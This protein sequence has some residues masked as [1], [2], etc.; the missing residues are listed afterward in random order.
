MQFFTPSSLV[1]LWALPALW[2]L[3]WL[4][5]RMWTARVARIGMPQ[6]LT[7]KLMPLYRPH[8]WQ[9]RAILLTLGILFAVLALA[10]PQW[11]SEK[12]KIERQGID[13][14]FLLDTSLSMLA[15]DAKPN[16]LEKSKLE[17][18][19]F[20]R[21][22]KGDRVG[23]VAFAGSGFLQTPL[24]LDYPAFLLFLDGVKTG[25]IPDPGTSLDQAIHVAMESM[26]EKELKHKALV[27]FSDG[28]DHEGGLER[29]IDEAKKA[30][31]RVYTVGVGSAQ[32]EPIQLSD[33]Q[34]RRVG[35][36]KDASGKMIMTALN[37]PLL[38]KI[39]DETG[40]LYLPGTPGE[41]EIEL[42]LRHM[43]SIGKRQFKERLITE[44]EEHFQLFLALGLL[45]LA[46]EMLVRSQSASKSRR[47]AARA[48]AKVLPLA[49]CL[50]LF[51]GFLFDSPQRLNEKANKEFE[52][53]KYQTAME[54]YQKAQVSAPE[55]P[56]LNYNLATTQYQT[57]DYQQAAANLE[58]T[59]EKAQ[60]PALKAKA[61]YNYGNA[62]YRLG[63]FEKAIEAYQKA[64][65][66]DPKDVD[67]K[68]NLELIEKK[69][70]AFDKKNQDRKKDQQKQQKQNQQ[71]Q[72]QQ[73]NQ[74]QQNQQQNQQQQNQQNQQNQQ[75]QQQDQQDKQD[76]QDQKDQQN[77]KDKQDQQD[78]KDQQNQKDKQDQQDQKDQQN[79]KDKQ[80]QQ[81]QKDQQKKEEQQRQ[82]EEQ[83][84]KE[85]EQRQREEQQKREEE[86]RQREEQ[87]KR[88][89]EE[90]KQREEQKKKE[91]EERKKEEEQQ[92][93]QQPQEQKE[94]EP[95]EGNPQGGGRQ[96]L[97][98]QMSKD[99]A[100]RILDALKETEKE[101]QDLRRPPLRR[102]PKTVDKD[103]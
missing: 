44:K 87:Q 28:E 11:G 71:Q 89:E 43:Q 22:L 73:Q 1:F 46:L 94:Q 10:R 3:V 50:F 41:E 59:L 85:E 75:G 39:A 34:G 64:L 53:K 69:K 35:F 24:T 60:D 86:T 92:K 23:M 68:Y 47:T 66:I 55:D 42:I 96:P 98:G 21:R 74:Q 93:E 29:A 62:Q 90:Q 37:Q 99:Q 15:E 84:K 77:Q 32:G 51:S 49:A 33:E 48:V 67:A 5:R 31:T 13:I 97:Q 8:A 17:I 14:I 4:G 102:D 56:V 95:K 26:P 12:K 30:G 91:E 18:K 20:V 101:L 65:E 54:H 19:H 83:Q 78:Q 7:R 88:E 2:F 79:Q 61:L 52:E 40:G 36:K 80:D 25:Y 38:E 72:N 81:D 82:Q 27:L 16:R 57:K 103:W 70:G 6:T 9:G 63:N 45:F 76:Q 100:L 58:Q